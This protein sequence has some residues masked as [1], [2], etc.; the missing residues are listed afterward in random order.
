MASLKLMYE[1]DLMMN[2]LSFFLFLLKLF[3]YLIFLDHTTSATLRED[4]V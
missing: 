1:Y 4:V 2:R 3:F